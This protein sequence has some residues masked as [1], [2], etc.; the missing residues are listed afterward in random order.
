MCVCLSVC[1]S[2]CVSV[3][4]L[5]MCSLNVF[6]PPLL[7]VGSPIFL[8]IRDPW[9]KVMKRNGLRIKQALATTLAGKHMATVLPNFALARHLQ[10]VESI[11]TDIT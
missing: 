7:K 6:L 3:C 11:V 5:L 1:V 8:E 9:G 4:S 2:V 10:R